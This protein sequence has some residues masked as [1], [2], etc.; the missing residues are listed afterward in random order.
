VIGKLGYGN[1]REVFLS[2]TF[3][4]VERKVHFI[5]KEHGMAAED[6]Q[7]R[8]YDY[9]REGFPPARP[10]IATKEWL[11]VQPDSPLAMD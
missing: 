9:A 6:E 11:G 10:D 4:L 1:L 7:N 5:I 8:K 3:N 2:K